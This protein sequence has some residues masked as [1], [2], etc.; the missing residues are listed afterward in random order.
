[1]ILSKDFDQNLKPRTGEIPLLI[2][3]DLH[4]CFMNHRLFTH[5]LAFDKP[6]NGDKMMGTTE[7]LTRDPLILGRTS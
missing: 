7:T 4:R 2:L 5:Y 6:V 3:N 1:V